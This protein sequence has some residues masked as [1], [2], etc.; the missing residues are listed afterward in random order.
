MKYL[1][2]SLAALFFIEFEH[3]Q[4]SEAA[5]CAVFQAQCV[6]C[7]EFIPAEGP[8]VTFRSPSANPR[9]AVTYFVTVHLGKCSTAVQKRIRTSLREAAAA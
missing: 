8:S 3:P 7:N 5:R 6:E 2:R 1:V 9:E 4:E